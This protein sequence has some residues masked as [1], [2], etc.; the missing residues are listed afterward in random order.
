MERIHTIHSIKTN[1][2][3]F[4]SDLFGLDVLQSENSIDVTAVRFMIYLELACSAVVGVRELALVCDRKHL[5]A[6]VRRKKESISIDELEPCVKNR[7]KAQTRLGEAW[8]SSLPFHGSGLCE[9]V[10]MMPPS[11]LKRSV[12]NCT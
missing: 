8:F 10:M 3:L 1:F 2:K 6:L 7:R 12:K 5:G 4:R 11:A 9:A